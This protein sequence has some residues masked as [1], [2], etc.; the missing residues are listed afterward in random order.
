MEVGQE[1]SE[2]IVDQYFNSDNIVTLSNT[3]VQIGYSGMYD[4]IINRNGKWYYIGLRKRYLLV[5]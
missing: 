1:V 3:I 4:T 2:V 5:S